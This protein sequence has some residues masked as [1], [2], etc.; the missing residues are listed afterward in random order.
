MS[1]C[2]KKLAP[3]SE[4]SW[5]LAK[6]HGGREQCGQWG[7]GVWGHSPPQN[8]NGRFPPTS[9]YPNTSTRHYMYGNVRDHKRR[10]KKMMPLRVPSGGGHP[11]SLAQATFLTA[12]KMEPCT[13]YKQRWK[14]HNPHPSCPVIT[15]IMV[16]VDKIMPKFITGVIAELESIQRS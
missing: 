11:P 10:R 13:T 1:R 9:I 6:P 2:H 16:G 14:P 5:K 3:Y 4:T 7:G 8:V 12:N 15:N